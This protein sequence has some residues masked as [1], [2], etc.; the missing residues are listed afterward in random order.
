MMRKA[1]LLANLVRGQQDG[2]LLENAQACLNE[3]ENIKEVEA[4]K[5]LMQAVIDNKKA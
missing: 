3:I 2:D 4:E 5:R 1:R